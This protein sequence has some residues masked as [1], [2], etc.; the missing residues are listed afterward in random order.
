MLDQKSDS[1]FQDIIDPAYAD[2]SKALI[3]TLMSKYKLLDHFNSLRKYLLLGQGDFINHLMDLM[4]DELDK[5]SNQL[6][7]HHLKRLLDKAVTET[8]AQFDPPNI[9]SRLDIRL[10]PVININKKLTKK[11]IK[12]Y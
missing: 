7:S 12:N 3:K 2:T 5:P 10:L 11:L 6:M 4:E 1:Q 9:I 8:N